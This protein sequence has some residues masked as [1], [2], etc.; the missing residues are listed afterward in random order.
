MNYNIETIDSTLTGI[1]TFVSDFLNFLDRNAIKLNGHKKP[2]VKAKITDGELISIGMLRSMLGMDCIKTF[3]ALGAGMLKHC[4]PN[5]P[6]YEGLIKG[7]CRT[8]PTQVMILQMW[9]M[10]AKK[11]CRSAVF[12]ADATPY[13]VCHNKRIFTHKVFDGLAKRGKSSMGWFYGFKIHLVT[14][15]FGHLLALKITSGEVNERAPFM[16]LLEFLKGTVVADAA[17]LSKD[18]SEQLW[19]K[20][21]H[22][23]TGTR[24]NMKK[25]MTV[26]QHQQ[27]KS[28]Q[29]I[30]V[31]FGLL[32]QRLAL[33]SSL[34][35]SVL[36]GIS[37][38]CCSFLAYFFSY[39]RQAFG[40]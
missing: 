24:K 40:Y 3:Y 38:I 26:P 14:D 27:L 35:R 23:L 25:L 6:R 12:L 22:L 8:V 31:T 10:M 37:R 18:L 5:L 29:R 7:L 20:S 4:F 2:G 33:V 1:Y 21:I 13:P 19:E 9:L 28:R 32:K 15:E 36:G 17:Y 30:E 34:S 39:Q 16:Q 11:S